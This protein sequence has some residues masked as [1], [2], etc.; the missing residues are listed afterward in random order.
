MDRQDVVLLRCREKHADHAE[1][2][3]VRTASQ[4]RYDLMSEHISR[5]SRDRHGPAVGTKTSYET[6]MFL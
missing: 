2:D 4:C 5:M 3:S 6:K 1:A